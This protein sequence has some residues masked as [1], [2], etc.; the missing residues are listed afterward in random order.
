MFRYSNL[1]SRYVKNV[2]NNSVRPIS[3]RSIK[4]IWSIYFGKTSPG[5][6]PPY[7]HIC[8]IGDPVLRII[9]EPIDLKTIE[10]EEFQKGLDHMY[11][12]MKKYD[13]IGLAAPQ[14]GF[15]WR[16]FA[17]EITEKYL[18]EVERNTRIICAMEAQPLI[19]FVNP[20][21]TVIDSTELVFQE[22]CAS[23]N[24]FQADVPRAK[25]IEIKALDR[26]GNPFTWR[27]R[28]W[29]ARV[30]QHENDHLCGVLYTDRMLPLSFEYCFWK[31]YNQNDG[32]VA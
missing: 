21:L 32:R 27:A 12:V 16:V 3:F 11:E 31:N 17:I 18:K 30:A 1:I 5:G 15:S 13:T 20:K 23:I 22:M 9:A 14:I 6:K 26:F 28:N 7:D 4:K 2:K 19:Y 29:L 10:T 24:S 25:E 8:Q